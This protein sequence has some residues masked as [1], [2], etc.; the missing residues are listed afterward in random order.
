[1]DK[2]DDAGKVYVF[3][4]DGNLLTT[5]TSPMPKAEA[6]FG[7]EGGVTIFQDMIIIGEYGADGESKAEG[8][9]YVFAKDGNLLETLKAPEPSE[10]AMY[11]EYVYAGRD[12]FA[13]YE[14]GT[15]Q[16]EYGAGRVMRF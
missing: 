14:L 15:V 2:L 9:A 6:F 11:G 16:G 10:N 8:R 1:V 7:C 5:I 3:D 13:V 12:V 4:L